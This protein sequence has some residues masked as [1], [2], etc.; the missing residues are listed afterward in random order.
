M[1]TGAPSLLYPISHVFY[2]QVITHQIMQ[3]LSEREGVYRGEDGKSMLLSLS[4]D[5]HFPPCGEV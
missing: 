1:L 3:G 2:R 4:I 5:A